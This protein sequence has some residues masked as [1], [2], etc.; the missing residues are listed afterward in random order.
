MKKVTVLVKVGDPGWE[1]KDIDAI[2]VALRKR[3]IY[4]TVCNNQQ[5]FSDF[6]VVLGPCP[7]AVIEDF[8]PEGVKYGVLDPTSNEGLQTFFLLLFENTRTGETKWKLDM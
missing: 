6:V 2:G 1:E 3:G 8:I 4:Y 7:T 5:H